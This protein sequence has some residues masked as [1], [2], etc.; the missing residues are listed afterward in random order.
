MELRPSGSPVHDPRLAAV[1]RRHP[2]VDLV[3]LPP[4]EP[5]PDLEPV[6]PASV[7]RAVELVGETAAALWSAS[8]P[9][10]EQVPDTR[11]RYA[12]RESEVRAVARVVERRSDGFAVLV[13]LRHEL[14]QR[15]WQVHR[16]AGPQPE[17]LERLAAGLDGGTVLASYAQESGA[18][19]V[20]LASAPLPV[21]VERA[22]ELVR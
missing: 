10:S 20:E 7:E 12:A 3:E 6:G 16:A 17:A 9:L 21:G 5:A 19:V 2:D 15:G 11:V 4:E 13:R 22:R 1:R 8:A 14:E 18:L